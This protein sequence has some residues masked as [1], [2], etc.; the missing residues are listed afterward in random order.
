MVTIDDFA[1]LDIRVV[2]VL[3]ATRMEGSKK[4]LK[5]LVDIGGENRQILS[6]IGKSYQPEDIIG[7][8]L[9]AIV[10]LEPRN[11]MGEESQGMILATGDDIEN[12]TLL[13]PIKEVANGSK[14]R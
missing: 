8:Q 4:L 7:K 9:I 2:K 11:M 12:I 10:N 5:L 14:I 1:K 13:E 6:G 3:E